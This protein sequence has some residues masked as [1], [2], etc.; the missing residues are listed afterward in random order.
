[1][2]PSLFLAVLVGLF[3]AAPVQAQQDLARTLDTVAAMWSRGD[4]T[5][6]AGLA[7][8][9]GIEIEVHG[10][11]LGRVSGRKAA[12]AFRHLFADQE[13]VSVRARMTSRVTGTDRSA[14]CELTWDL[15]PR[16]SMVPTR[17]T[18]FLGLVREGTSWRV[19]QVRVLR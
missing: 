11:S 9:D 13:T 19:S 17:T 16:G 10:A 3:S 7:A 6:L 18:V 12:A 4:A 14:F 5:A 1:V 8:S 2:R 15:R